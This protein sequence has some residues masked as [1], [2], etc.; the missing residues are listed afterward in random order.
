M[1]SCNLETSTSALPRVPSISKCNNIKNIYEHGEEA[2]WGR[3]KTTSGTVG[4]EGQLEHS[5]EP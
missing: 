5:V 4:L 2:Q 1:S 3:S